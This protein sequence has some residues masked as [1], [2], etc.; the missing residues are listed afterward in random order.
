MNQIQVHILTVNHT[1][2]TDEILFTLQESI[3]QM[4]KQAYKSNDKNGNEMKNYGTQ[5]LSA[6]GIEGMKFVLQLNVF[7]T[8]PLI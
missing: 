7:S 4:E 2:K 5:T 1:Y 6:I 3:G 8:W